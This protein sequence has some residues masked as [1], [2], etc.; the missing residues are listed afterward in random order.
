MAII[1][2][3]YGLIFIKSR[4]TA[5]TSIEVDLS[6]RVAPGDIVTPII[7]PVTGHVPRNFESNGKPVFRNHM[8]A[9]E[10]RDRIGKTEFDKMFKFCVEREPVSKCISHFHMLRNSPHHNRDNQYR[11]NWSEYVE[12]ENFPHD[13]ERYC[14]ESN[15]ELIPL[16]DHFVRYENLQE[17]LRIILNHH[18]IPRFTL[19]ATAKSEYSKHKLITPQQVSANE[20]D[21]I[22]Q[23]FAIS[24]EIHGLYT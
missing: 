24:N 8:H 11:L 16:V 3:E 17:E 10:I 5:G 15:G 9:T 18:G 19:T 21:K 20:R 12:Q 2:F 7:P 13:H 23:R 4:K 6:K 1:S 14:E 22:Y